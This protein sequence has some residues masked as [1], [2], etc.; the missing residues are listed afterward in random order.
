M[1]DPLG[2]TDRLNIVLDIIE[3]DTLEAWTDLYGAE[4]VE[5]F[6][7]DVSNI[8]VTG[9]T[10]NDAVELQEFPCKRAAKIENKQCH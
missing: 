3:P 10:R 6:E 4:F 5:H 7:N 9:R 8:T 2:K 1:S